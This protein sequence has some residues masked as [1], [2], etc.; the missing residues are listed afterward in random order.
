MTRCEIC[1]RE[2]LQVTYPSGQTRMVDAEQV[3]VVQLAEGRPP[4]VEETHSGHRLHDQ[5]C[6]GPDKKPGYV[7]QG[8]PW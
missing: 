8:S 1:G 4:K 2:V 5:S 6:P 3:L 7:P